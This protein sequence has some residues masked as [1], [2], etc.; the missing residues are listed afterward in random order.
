[1]LKEIIFFQLERER[2]S[3]IEIIPQS[4]LRKYLMF[5]RENIHPKL[6]H[7]PQEKISKVFAEMRK[8]SLVG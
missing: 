8:E 3:T 5:A 1:M 6:D 4:L 2:D 7:I